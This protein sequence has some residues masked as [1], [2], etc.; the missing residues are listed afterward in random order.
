MLSSLRANRI[1]STKGES[2][3]LTS[4]ITELSRK[5]KTGQLALIAAP[6]SPAIRSS[7]DLS[8]DESDDIKNQCCSSGNTIQLDDSDPDS[9]F[10][11]LMLLSLVE[12]SPL[13]Q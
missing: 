12:V 11:V 8:P 6:T 2:I 4:K 3:S 10:I 5:S 7:Q 13:R 9:D 1:C